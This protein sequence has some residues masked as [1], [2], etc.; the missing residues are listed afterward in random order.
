MLLAAILA[1]AVSWTP[2]CPLHESWAFSQQVAVCQKPCPEGAISP[3]LLV[4]NPSQIQG[5]GP[6]MPP[7]PE[8][9][10]SLTLSTSL[11]DDIVRLY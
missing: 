6:Q 9:T 4:T 11:R 1:E 7:L 2:T 3:P 5:Q 8:R 10:V